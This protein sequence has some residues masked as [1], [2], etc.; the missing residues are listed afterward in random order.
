MNLNY[1]I[2]EISIKCP[3]CNENCPD[4]NFAVGQVIDAVSKFECEH[5]GKK[6]WISAHISYDSYSDCALNNI[7]HDYVASESHPTVFHCKNCS[8]SEVREKHD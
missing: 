7:D 4:E 8:Q 3:Y 1:H 2:G 5:C 6:F